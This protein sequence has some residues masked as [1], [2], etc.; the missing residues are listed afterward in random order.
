MKK[1]LLTT[2]SPT[3][4]CYFC[5]YFCF[6]S[7]FQYFFTTFLYYSPCAI[8]LLL[9]SWYYISFKILPPTLLFCH[10]FL[11]YPIILLLH[12][13]LHLYYSFLLLIYYYISLLLSH[14]LLPLLPSP[15][16]SDVLTD[17]YSQSTPLFSRYCLYVL[18]FFF[19]CFFL[20]YP[21]LLLS[22]TGRYLYYHCHCCL[23]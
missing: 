2:L 15:L 18:Y 14:T 17:L 10:S 23:T 9:L 1:L 5:C 13:I 20:Y 7:P 6:L 12:S 3:C 22:P 8:P 19:F 11:Y 16:L 21:S 4:Y